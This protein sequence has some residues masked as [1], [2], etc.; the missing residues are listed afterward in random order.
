MGVDMEIKGLPDRDRGCFGIYCGLSASK[1]TPSM[2]WL[3]VEVD[4]KEKEFLAVGV[5]T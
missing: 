2:P 3:G 5:L 1:S 4:A